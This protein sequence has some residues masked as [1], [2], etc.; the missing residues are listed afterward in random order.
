MSDRIQ[1]SST[2]RN[3][4]AVDLGQALLQGQAADRGLFMPDRYPAFSREELAGLQDRSY[5]EVAFE[6]LRRFTGG[7]MTRPGSSR[8]AT[9]PT[10]TRSR[11][12]TSRGAST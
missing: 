7:V 1:F 11:S 9:T 8:C 6:V 4:P 5:P 2:N 3:V 10:T 12:S